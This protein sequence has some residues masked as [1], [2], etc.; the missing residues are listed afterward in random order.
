[1]TS[2]AVAGLVAARARNRRLLAIAAVVVGSAGVATLA[3]VWRCVGH[4]HSAAAQMALDHGYPAS[5]A[6]NH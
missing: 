5:A 3:E 4:W 1:M 6:Q 2:D